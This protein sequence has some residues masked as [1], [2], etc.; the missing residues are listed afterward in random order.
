MQRRKFLRTGLA[1]APAAGL[2]TLLPTQANHP[3]GTP[4]FTVKAGKDRFPEP[5]KH[6]GTSP[7]LV[8]VSA[9]DTNGQF[10]VFEYEGMARMGPDLHVHLAQDETFYVLD[11][12]YL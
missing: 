7:N 1:A 9:K 6:R 2:A 4:W 11:G 10:C 12:E 3:P 5:T 8:K